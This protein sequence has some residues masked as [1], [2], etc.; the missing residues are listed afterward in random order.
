VTAFGS[1]QERLARLL[2]EARMTECYG[3]WTIR[4]RFK[5]PETREEWEHY[6]HNPHPS[7]L[8]AM[9]QAK[10]ILSEGVPA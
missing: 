6:Q 10:A 8:Q 9:A 7:I 3:N 1:R 4:S 2:H 5:W